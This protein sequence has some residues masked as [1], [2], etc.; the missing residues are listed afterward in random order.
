MKKNLITFL[1]ALFGFGSAAVQAQNDFPFGGFPGFGEGGMPD[2]SQFQGMGG[3]M[4]GE[5][6]EAPTGNVEFSSSNLPLILIDTDSLRIT[7]REKITARMRIINK[8]TEQRNTADDPANDYDGFVGI[9]IRGNS[10]AAFTQKRYTIELRNNDGSERKASLLGMPADDDWVLLGPYNDRS[11]MR[12]AMACQLWNS[13]GHWAP[14]TCYAELLLNGE[15]RGVYLVMEKIKQGADR[16]NI[17]KLKPEDV[18]GQELTG[19]Y[20]LRIDA[21]DAEEVTF[22][23]TVDGVGSAPNFGGGFGGGF[24]GFDGG[25]PGFGGGEMPDFSAFG[26]GFPGFGGAPAASDAGNKLQ[27]PV[28]WSIFYPKKKNLQPQQQQYIQE[29]IAQAEAAIQKGRGYEKYIDV[30]SFVDYFIHT[31][32]SLNADGFKRS[33]Y[34]YK[35]KAD[36]KGRGGLLHAGTVWDY[37]LAYGN[38]NFC[39]ANDIY[40]WVYNGCETN[41]TPAMW[42]M[43]ASQKSF[44]KLV[45]KRYAELRK[46]VLSLE[47]L[48][49]YID[50]NASLL[51]E[52]QERHYTKY[53][54]LLEG[55]KLPESEGDAAAAGANPMGGMFGGMFGGMAMGGGD[56]SWFDAYTVPSYAEEIKVLKKWLADRLAFLDSQ[57]M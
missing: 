31:E 37:N 38:C 26:G 16:I 1:A 19:G 3:G 50:V 54:T 57:W 33:A 14:R 45:R 41:P 20:I 34:F 9:K 18:E 47:S 8:G 52:A 4:F 2:F 40:A 27:H 36:E 49:A 24:P 39:S 5:M 25:F 30:P 43:L 23:S 46:S 51:S 53:P 32:L 22:P 15:Y 12:D 44:M 21:P 6:P 48:Y 10:S 13:M 55:G 11:M 29:Y 7:Q 42:K 56:T 28:T 35:E 17:S